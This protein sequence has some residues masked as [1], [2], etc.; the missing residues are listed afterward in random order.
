M[1]L[2]VLYAAGWV[3]FAIG[4]F[5]SVQIAVVI[6]LVFALVTAFAWATK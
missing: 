6:A 5:V 3:V 4:A 2:S 1:L